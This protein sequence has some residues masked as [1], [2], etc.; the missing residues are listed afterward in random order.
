[1]KTPKI[2]I[3][4]ISSLILIAASLALA[5]CASP[6]QSEASRAELTAPQS[7]AYADIRQDPMQGYWSF[8]QP[9]PENVW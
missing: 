8:W 1:M 9:S 3:T 5:G 2:V 6:G 4:W 7:L